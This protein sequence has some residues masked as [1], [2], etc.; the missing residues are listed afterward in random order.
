MAPTPRRVTARMI[1]NAR[2]IYENTNVPV[3]DIA[4]MLGVTRRTFYKRRKTWGWKLRYDRLPKHE[5][6]REPDE[7]EPAEPAM[8]AAGGEPSA[9]DVIAARMRGVIESELDAV[10]QIVAKL[11]PASD[12][13][14]EAE[15]AARVLAS[16]ARTL[17]EIARLDRKPAAKDDTTDDDRGP[18]DPDEFLRELARRM[19]AFARAPED[20]VSDVA[21]RGDA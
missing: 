5:P 2:R 1:A 10:E 7:I 17:H 21:P 9:T 8:S 18:D 19:D 20:S 15:R 16:L 12:H 4:A 11:R 6:P 14:E 13:T 3:D